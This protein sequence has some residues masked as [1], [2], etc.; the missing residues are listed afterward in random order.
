MFGWFKKSSPQAPKPSTPT[1]RDTLFGDLPWTQW[2]SAP[3]PVESQEPWASFISARVH[4]ENGNAPEAIRI[5]QSILAQEGWESRH[6]A[7]A[8][9]F[10]RQLGVQPEPALAKQLLGVIFE[11]GM[12][13]G[14]DILAAY[15]DGTAR[16]YNFGGRGVVWEAPD[17]SL[18]API[19]A[20]L[21]AGKVVVDLTGPGS[22]K[23]PPPPTKDHVRLSML[24]PNGIHFGQ[25]RFSA[26]AQD[27]VGG[28]VINAATDLMQQLIALDRT[29]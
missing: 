12:D 17:D 15:P 4:A 22:G 7:Q 10:L 9:H 13:K 29:P 14:L 28:S 25:G 20:L 18:D 2:P 6:Y 16:Y 5:L 23:R 11:V 26:L 27:L 3:S 24:T 8:W 21:T 19:N 1:L